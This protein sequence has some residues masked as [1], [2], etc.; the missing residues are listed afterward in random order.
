MNK[1][2]RHVATAAAF[3]AVMALTACGGGS[4]S[5][6]SSNS[7]GASSTLVVNSSP[8]MA[9]LHRPHHQI[10]GYTHVAAY[11]A[12]W[13]MQNAWAAELAG[14][15][16]IVF[17]GNGNQIEPT[18]SD[19]DMLF[20]VVPPDSYRVCVYAVPPVTPA[21]GDT[22]CGN[23]QPVGSDEVVVVTAVP[24][25]GDTQF[26]VDVETREDNIAIFQNPDRPNQTY[27]CHKGVT[28]SVG[29]PAS[30]RGHQV[31][32]DPLGPCDNFGVE[33]ENIDGSNNGN[34]NG[35]RG[36][37]GNDNRCNKG[38]PKKGCGGGNEQV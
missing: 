23:P 4:S 19:P 20:Y 25:N 35:N 12:K 7:G 22:E 18:T 36:G 5:S 16:V 31:H 8:S 1:F 3:L 15:E 28:K 33:Q 6:G 2:K 37:K 17:N 11:V 10:Q 32:G 24:N 14:S 21:P 9:L 30:T 29:T 26:T 34:N 13:L 38:K 27:I